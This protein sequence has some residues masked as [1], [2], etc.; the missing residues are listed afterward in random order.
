MNENDLT[1]MHPLR[2]VLDDVI[3]QVTEGKGARHGGNTSPFMDQRWVPLAKEFGTGGLLFQACKK[4]QESAGKPTQ[5]DFEREVIGAIAYAGMAILA[6][7]K[8]IV[9]W[10]TK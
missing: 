3:A 4:L 5:E 7:R 8:G 10:T 1:A 9:P 2:E 6:Y